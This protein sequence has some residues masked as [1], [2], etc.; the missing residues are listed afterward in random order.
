MNKKATYL[1]QLFNNVKTEG[2]GG[3]EQMDSS[4]IFQEDMKTAVYD[5]INYSL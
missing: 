4:L 2:G 1:Y 3:R 5:K